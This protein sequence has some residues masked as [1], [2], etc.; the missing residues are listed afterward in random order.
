MNVERQA[1]LPQSLLLLL[2]S[3]LPVLGAVLLAPVLPRMQEHFADTPGVAVLVPIAL[4]LPALM[5]ALLAPFAGIIADRLGRKPLLI[6]A[7]CLYTVCGVLPLWLDSLQ[8]IVVS[9]AGIGLA[10]AAIMT[11]CTTMMGDY[12]SGAR[13][14]RM[15]ALQ[16]VATSL[17]AAIF[18]A[19]GGVLGEHGWRTPFALYGLGLVLLPLMAW[20][21]W[22]PHGRDVAA[23]KA[24]GATFP[25]RAL[26]PLYGLAFLAGLSLFIV[27][28]QVGYLLNLLHVEGSQ[29]IG[30]TMGASQLGVLVGA[31]SFR[32]FS[33]VPAHRQML[34]AFVAAGIG[35]GLLAV[36]D[37]HG[38]VVIAVLINGLGIGLMMPTLLTWIMA[39]VDFQQRGRAAGGFTSMFFAGEFVSP[40]VV[41][42]IT[43]GVTSA[44]PAALGIVAGVQLLVAVACIRL[45]GGESVFPAA[46]AAKP[47][48]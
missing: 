19:I 38:W 7:M 6:G 30:L 1:R 43:G 8:A 15:F 32:L 40:L 41:L 4:T 21:L 44:L 26:A 14:E 22:E 5:I 27:P 16:M 35:G 39:Q 20:L 45:R 25:W 13:R 28:V 33:G 3:C 18:I 24:A 34:L 31:L 10:E 29:Q 37:S 42:A 17:S 11:C 36:A 12:Y 46:V 48:R 2:G 9:R 23:K 47:D